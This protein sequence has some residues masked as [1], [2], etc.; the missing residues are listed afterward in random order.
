MPI[1]RARCRFIMGIDPD[2]DN[3]GLLVYDRQAV[4]WYADELDLFALIAW[5]Q[6]EFNPADLDTIIEAGWKNPSYHHVA[7]FNPRF[8]VMSEKNKLAFIARAAMD[9]GENFNVGK[10]ID[11]RLK[12]LSYNT[13]LV[14]PVS[15]KLNAAEFMRR[16]KLE[17]GY[18]ETIR[19]AYRTMEPFI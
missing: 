18:N 14:A 8:K 3:S 4:K 19:D 11:K 16:T 2:V 17:H 6:K 7:T 9:V 12:Q 5:I 10:Q 13:T 1:H 15:A